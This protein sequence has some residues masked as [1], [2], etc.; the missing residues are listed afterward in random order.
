MSWTADD[1]HLYQHLERELADRPVSDN[2]KIDVLDAYKAY[3]DAYNKYYACIRAR[4]MCGLPEEDP[5]YMI[6]ED[7]SS[8]AARVSNIA[9]ENYYAI[10]RRLFR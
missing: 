6:L 2:D 1:Q 8:E 5:E 3:L 4:D 7:A 10:R 9:W